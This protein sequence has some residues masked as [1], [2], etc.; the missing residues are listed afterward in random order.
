MPFRLD[1]IEKDGIPI[2]FLDE[3]KAMVYVGP[4]TAVAFLDSKIPLDG[5]HYLLAGKI[6]FTNG[7]IL[8]ANFEINTHTFEFLETDT[9]KVFIEEE[10]TWYYIFDD[11]LE[12]IIGLDLKNNFTFKWIPDIPLDFHKKSPYSSCR[13]L[14]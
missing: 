4:C 6:E 11:K 8:R 14:K 5:R 9:V 2:L 13:D 1:D 10:R 12:D 3:G 7:K